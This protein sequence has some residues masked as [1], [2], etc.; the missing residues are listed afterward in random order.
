M[1]AEMAMAPDASTLAPLRV[2]RSEVDSVE[3]AAI[4]RILWR[5]RR[6]IA[7]AGAGAFLAALAYCLLA[8]P[9]YTATAQILID[10]RDKQ[11]VANDVNPSSIAADGGVTQVESQGSVLLS[12][13]VLKR[14]VAATHLDADPE[15]NGSG[16]LH[17]LSS[18]FSWLSRSPD[19][20]AAEQAARARTLQTLRKQAHYNRA[21]KALVLD[22]K[23]TARTP[24]RAAEIANAIAA[25]YRDDQRES[26]AAAG[27][28]ASRELESRLGEMQAD[29]AHKEAAVEDYRA[30][31]K[32][33][34]STGQL[35]SDQEINQ[36][37]AQLSGAQKR[38]ASLKAQLD[39]LRRNAGTESTPE[40]MSSAVMAKLRDREGALVEKL[41]S[42]GRLLGP[43]HPDIASLQQSLVEVRGLIVKETQRLRQAAEA[44]YAR[45]YADEKAL[46]AKLDGMKNKSLDDGKADVNLRELQR[47]AEASRTIY[48]AF[49]VRARET[50]EASNV[51]T[52]N[53]RLITPAEPPLQKS[54]PTTIPLLLGATFLGLSLGAAG[55]LG[56]EYLKPNLYTAA[57]LRAALDAPVLGTISAQD[58]ENQRP[59]PLASAAI[60][61]L[62]HDDTESG[63][64][65]GHCVFLASSLAASAARR[66]FA[67][68]LAAFAARE[69]YET[70]LIDADLANEAASESP[71]LR[72]LLRGDESIADLADREEGEQFVRLDKGPLDPQ[73][74]R[75][76]ES[77]DGFRLRRVR[78]C[79]DLVVIDMGAMSENGR[80]APLA[81]QADLRLFVATTGEPLA[82]LMREADAAMAAATRFDAAALVESDLG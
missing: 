16:L 37:T 39:Q 38:V 15:F 45:A 7:I 55:A 36:A 66:L 21:D 65:V 14:A 13:T 30:A 24:V 44:D 77:N 3:T 58:L 49:L 25:A 43:R 78:R 68:R 22:L 28:D 82:D 81:S 18:G 5:R 27:R 23:V 54:W 56:R 2:A 70:V 67:E 41:A 69:G 4:G 71:G 50:M 46:G 10:P 40:A 62:P 1:R 72:D 34:V 48:Q 79:Y 51:D 35:V 64:G 52:T 29:L 59:N 53:A 47:Q 76:R 26:R 8:T 11:V 80:L 57:Q 19:A 32:F 9:Q 74:G 61:A 31:H 33:V 75:R 17:A 73:T 63:A 12:D 60:A 20:G 6:G 42:A